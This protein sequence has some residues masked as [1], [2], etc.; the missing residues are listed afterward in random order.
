MRRLNVLRSKPTILLG[1]P[2]TI[3]LVGLLLGYVHRAISPTYAIIF[4]S[5]FL[6]ALVFAQSEKRAGWI[7]HNLAFVFLA[8]AMAELYFEFQKIN[9]SAGLPQY[10]YNENLGYAAKSGTYRA[11]KTYGFGTGVVFDVHYT[12]DKNGLRVAPESLKQSGPIVM[13]FGDS[14][15]F[16]EGVKDDQTLPNAFSIISGMRVLN[17]GQIG[18]GPHQMLRLLELDIPKK[19][20]TA[21]PRLMIYTAIEDHIARA[22]G[23]AGW[24][25]NGPLYED[26]NGRAQYVGSFSEHDLPCDP[27][28]IRR[29]A[30]EK[31]LQHSRI[32][33]SYVGPPRCPASNDQNTLR[34]DRTRFLDI[35]KT[36]NDIAQQK[37]QSR[38]FV[39]LW[40]VG[41]TE[42]SA[43]ENINWIKAKLRENDIPTL[44]LSSEV[45]DPEFKNWIIR[46]DGHPNPQA[47]REV[48]NV[49]LTWLKKNSAVAPSASR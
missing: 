21:L 2:A 43:A 14:F 24:D 13:F 16:G 32:W 45:N 47:Y 30:I 44:S 5:F 15:T 6:A 29:S 37:Y 23:R 36:A 20:T 42:N 33:E 41:T 31:L 4:F 27:Y 40:D 22:A 9:D 38:L 25:K 11:V 18:Y 10:V 35:V 46:R 8:M 7:I 3:I 17:F 49:L 26:Q 48:A 19:V 1:V 28:A 12:L 39:I 34:R